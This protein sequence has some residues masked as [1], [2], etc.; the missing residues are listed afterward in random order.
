MIKELPNLFFLK[1]CALNRESLLICFPNSER[2]NGRQIYLIVYWSKFLGSQYLREK[3]LMV[4]E[5][6]ALR[7]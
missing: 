4:E 1:F 7:G 2:E 5:V 6:E 3:G